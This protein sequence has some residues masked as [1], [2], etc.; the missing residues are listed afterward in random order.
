M[1]WFQQD[2]PTMVRSK[3]A[4]FLGDQGHLVHEI[5]PPKWTPRD[6]PIITV[7][8]DGPQPSQSPTDVELVRITVRSGV[9]SFSRKVLTD[10]E[11]F[12]T[13]PGLHLLGFSVSKKLGTRL[14][15]G[16]DSKI[17]GTYA[18]RVFAI[19]TTRKAR[20]NGTDS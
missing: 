14:I 3:V 2:A 8:S 10:I 17:G 7:V 18:S 16:P 4:E 13:T 6:G 1:F 15:A 20:K 11:S 9:L 12:L 19:S 5:M